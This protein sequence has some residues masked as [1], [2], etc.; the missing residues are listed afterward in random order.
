MEAFASIRINDVHDT[1]I[2]GWITKWKHHHP[3]YLV[4]TADM[5]PHLE[6]Y[7]NAQNFVHEAVRH[8][9][10]E[11]VQEI[12]DRYDIDGFELDYIRHPVLFSR[13][14]RGLPLMEQETNIITQF[15]RDIRRISD[16][17]ADRRCRPLLV[18]A[19]APNTFEQALDLGMDVQAWMDRDLIDMLIA[20][21]GYAPS[22]LDAASFCD[23]DHPYGL[24][25][26]PCI[27]QGPVRMV[28]NERW[29]EVERAL[30][31][32]WYEAGADDIYV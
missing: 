13:T 27:N 7:V 6:L 30:V 20:G 19:R 31:T 23:R 14:M 1:F 16:A 5:P 21:G 8:R 9:K 4:D 10:L 26:Y 18:A 12:C 17:A 15:M 32:N 29:A 2:P 24:P 11:I 3:E 28:S 22:T 25:V